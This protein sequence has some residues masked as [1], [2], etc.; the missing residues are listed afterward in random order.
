MPS[1]CEPNTGI[2]GVVVTGIDFKGRGT[3]TFV[4]DN[5]DDD[6]KVGGSGVVI[7]DFWLLVNA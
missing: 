7:G 2:T 1:Q 6:D 3:D 4:V 5:E